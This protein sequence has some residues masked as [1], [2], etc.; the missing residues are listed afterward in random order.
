MKIRF[1]ADADLNQAIVTGI[2]R[3]APEV[4]FETANASNLSGLSDLEILAFAAQADR[5]LVSHEQ[6]TMLKYFAE[7][8]A[9]QTSSGVIIVSQSL[10]IQE[11]ITS[12]IK[13]WQ[14][15]EAEDC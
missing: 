4:D 10:P 8:V 5:V 12:L 13:L 7:F 14:T 3:R 9:T 1:Q 6:R 2:I 15:S 11:V